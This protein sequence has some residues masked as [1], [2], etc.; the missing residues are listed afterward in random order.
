MKPCDKYYVDIRGLKTLLD[1]IAEMKTN[2]E[3][4]ADKDLAAVKAELKSLIDALDQNLQANLADDE[5]QQALIES[6]QEA[7][8]KMQDAD[9]SSSESI[10]KLQS[11]LE[12]LNN[13]LV[14]AIDTINKNVAD[15]FNTI[16]GGIDNEI[17]PVLTE[18]QNSMKAAQESI[19][20]LQDNVALFHTKHNEYEQKHTELEAAINDYKTANDA[21][22]E[23]D[24]TDLADY[25][26]SNDARVKAVEQDIA[27]VVKPGI[28]SNADAIA[29][30]QNKDNSIDQSIS[31]LQDMRNSVNAAVTSVNNLDPKVTDAVSKLEALTSTVN[32]NY[33]TL[34]LKIDTE[35]QK[36]NRVLE[37]EF[38]AQI[39]DIISRLTALENA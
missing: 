18:L 39:T 2:I 3:Q 1:K 35:V 31:E 27:D 37:E 24:K 14:T 9:T 6:I 21:V 32:G 20:T 29:A 10:S 7:I 11:D 28:K 12:T 30:L 4:D 17:R 13:N 33:S 16:N 15:G 36:I 19:T 23:A 25:K 22:V 26:T 38:R 34:D 5:K 8:N